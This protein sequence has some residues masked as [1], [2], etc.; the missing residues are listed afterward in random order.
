MKTS[1]MFTRPGA[2]GLA[3]I[4]L[5]AE[6]ADERDAA[7]VT[8]VDPSALVSAPNVDISAYRVPTLLSETSQGVSV[9]T[10]EEI[11]ARNA[12]SV[13]EVMNQIPGMHVD[14]VGGPGGTAS[15]YIR[16]SDPNQVLVLV[17]G[18]RLN[19]P[20]TSRGGAIDLSS[21]S[22]AYVERIEVIRGGGS[23][24]YGSDAMGGVINIVT[25]RGGADGFKISANAGLGTRGYQTADGALSGGNE[26]ARFRVGI[27]NLKDGLT[28]EGGTLDLT[29]FSGSL[30][31]RIADNAEL[32]MNA[33]GTSRGSTSFPDTSG[34]IRL[35]VFRDLEQRHANE[36]TLGAQLK[37]SPSE[38]V[39]M[40]FQLSNYGRTE[41]IQSPGI[42]PGF[43]I[44]AF[45]SHSQFS[46]NTALASATFRLPYASVLTA[47]Y[48]YLG[49]SGTNTTDIPAFFTTAFFTQDRT[50]NSGFAELKSS[51][52]TGLV[53]R[54]GVRYDDVTAFGGRA[55]PNA[56]VRYTLASTGTVL[57][58]NAGR[59]F[60]APSFYALSNPLVGDPNLVPET[61]VN[62]EVGVEQAFLGD[63][64]LASLTWFRNHFQN[65]IDFDANT[66]RLVNRSPVTAQGAEAELS[67]KPIDTLSVGIEATY[68]PTR[69]DA[70]DERIRNRPDWRGGFTITWTANER[71]ALGWRTLYVGTSLD[72]SV[73]T[74]IIT[75][76]PYW[77]TDVTGSYALNDKVTF[78]AAIDNLFDNNY[79]QYVG[80]T[81]PGVRFR[82]G[83]MA[84]F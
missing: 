70:T 41:N 34:G 62:A 67:V 52:V 39:D 32:R 21:L 47:G 59:G 71:I 10:A 55:S 4:A 58:A 69:I 77:R 9:I 31:V 79:E 45:D 61:S 74:G 66:Q 29:T 82:I 63:R 72:S 68:A 73:P 60:K 75:L 6:A 2:L 50:T 33:L 13:V 51:P 37:W 76:E 53:L 23:A 3:L 44:P 40:N 17:D 30:D 15:A 36:N 22:T 49:E 78:T 19:D 43:P 35:A 65:L 14:Q 42:S 80:F 18:V 8:P 28:S 26:A 5:T 24:L 16:G 12:S 56:G 20:T 48:E 81:N 64:A 57:K 38:T 7:A 84:R 11:R 46:R 25:K 83:V 27:S 1:G 54:A